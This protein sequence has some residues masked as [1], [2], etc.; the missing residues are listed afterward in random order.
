[1]QFRGRG[2][3]RGQVR[4]GSRWHRARY[5]YF[6]R[7][8]SPDIADYIALYI[9]L[10]SR[11]ARRI[12]SIM[13]R[14]V[15]DYEKEWQINPGIVNPRTGEPEPLTRANAVDDMTTEV[16]RLIDLGLDVEP[17]LLAFVSP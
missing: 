4:Y 7:W 5:N 8:I 17:E 14:K 1:V 12:M 13:R 3:R 9:P 15:L 2:R 16:L 10:R 6:S 11:R